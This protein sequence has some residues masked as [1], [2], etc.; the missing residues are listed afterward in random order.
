MADK[1]YFEKQIPN[2]VVLLDSAKCCTEGCKKKIDK[3]GFCSE[4]FDWFK[5]GLITR[6]GVKASDFEKKYYHYISAK[7]AA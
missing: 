7:K 5:A 4:H 6:E 2:N 3:A 1:K